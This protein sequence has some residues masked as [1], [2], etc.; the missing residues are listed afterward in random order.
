MTY[1]HSDPLTQ[2]FDD[3]VLTIA[4]YNVHYLNPNVKEIVDWLEHQSDQHDIVFFTR[5]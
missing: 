1:C 2:P 4:Q 3:E 5:S